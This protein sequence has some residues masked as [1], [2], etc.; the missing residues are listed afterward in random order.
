MG[1]RKTNREEA[2]VR[3]RLMWGRGKPHST[4]GREKVSVRE[5][6]MPG[7]ETQQDGDI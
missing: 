7:A 2:E 6:E 4:R 5:K 1:A 3:N